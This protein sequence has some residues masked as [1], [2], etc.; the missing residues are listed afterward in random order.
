M[1][2][3]LIRVFLGKI[4]KMFPTPLSEKQ[5]LEQYANKLIEKATL[6]AVIEEGEIFSLV[7]GYTENVIEN[8]AY[9]S[10]VASRTEAQGKGYASKLIRDFIDICKDKDLDAV[11]LYTDRCNTKAL[12][13]YRK[14][15]F[16]KLMLDNEQR[17]QDVHLIYYIKD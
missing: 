16:Q 5:D 10:I 7:A 9:I 15:G 12:E 2:V 14:I 6:C 8:K 13:M 17:K 4:D 1:N 3:N 11:H